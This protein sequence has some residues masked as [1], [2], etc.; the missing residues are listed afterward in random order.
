MSKMLTVNYNKK[1]IYNIIIENSYDRLSE[2]LKALGAENRKICIVTDS[3]AGRLLDFI[4]TL[5]KEHIFLSII[6]IANG[7]A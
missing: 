7:C 2:E 3:N 4:T 5:S 6:H 1:P